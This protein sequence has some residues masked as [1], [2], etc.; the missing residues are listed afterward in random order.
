[1]VTRHPS[2]SAPIRLPTGTR[3]SSRN[4]SA[5]SVDPASVRSGRTVTPG[6]SMG[7]A[8]QVM[9]LWLGASGSVRT[10][11]SH[12]SATSACEVQ[13]LDPLTT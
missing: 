12:Q 3:T 2:F 1:M 4:T 7:I 6:A 5:N 13:I 10:S 11:S 9:P 8:S